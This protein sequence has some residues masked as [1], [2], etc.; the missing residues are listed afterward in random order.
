M[1]RCRDFQRFIV[2]VY[3]IRIFLRKYFSIPDNYSQYLQ[4]YD[5]ESYLQLLK[6]II[7]ADCDTENVI[8][9]EILPHKQKTRIDFY[10]TRDYLHIPVVCITELIKEGNKLFYIRKNGNKIRV[11]KRIYNRVIFDDL[12]QQSPEIQ[13]KGK[14]LFEDLDVEWVPHPNWFYR[15]SKYTFHL[16]SI[17][18]FR[19][20]GF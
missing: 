6:D 16:L 13:E 15:I 18:M 20:H 9:L 3:I 17:L 8:L 12:Q 19:K 11:K 4:D 14:I 1:S 10:C 5:Q 2:S 7:V